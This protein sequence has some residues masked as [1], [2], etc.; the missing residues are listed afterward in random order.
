ATA[1]V[2]EVISASVADT[3]PVFDKILQSC[4]KL[5]DSSEQGIVLV[6]PEGHVTLAAHHGPA[7][8]ILRE[9]YDGGKVSAKAYV[10]GIL[11]DQPLHFVDTL[12]PDVH[13]TVRSVAQRLQIGPYS[14]VL[15]PMIWEGQAVGFLYAI[16]Q[17]A[18]GFSNKE[19]ALLETFANQAVIAIQNARLFQELQDRTQDLAHSVG[20]FRA[21]ADV[22]HAVNS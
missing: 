7:L 2:L 17:P 21:L 22:S 6:A 10:K 19:I 4:E 5:F 3:R 11:L 14:Q 20:Q 9:I 13:W 12:D 15:A 16:R 18:T 8:S 1:E